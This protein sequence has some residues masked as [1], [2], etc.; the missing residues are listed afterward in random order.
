MLRW[1]S[2]PAVVESSQIHE[3]PS[4]WPIPAW[5]VWTK[6]GINAAPSDF[7]QG[8]SWVFQ[9]NLVDDPVMNI[10][11]KHQITWFSGNTRCSRARPRYFLGSALGFIDLS[12][13]L[14]NSFWAS[15]LATD[16]NDPNLTC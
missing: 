12:L 11:M 6:S 8:F 4:L 5:Q 14:E 15:L 7:A 9:V 3:Y 2:E 16:L 1:V 10:T 13:G